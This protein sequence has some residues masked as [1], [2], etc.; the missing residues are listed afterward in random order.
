M[1]NRLP[2]KLTALRKHFGYSQGDMAEK[3]V[4][5]VAEYM[6]WENGNTI[7]RIDQLRQLARIYRVPIEDLADNTRTV[8]L[9]RLDE[10]ADSIQISF[11][12]TKSTDTL[13]GITAS[14]VSAEEAEDFA[15]SLIAKSVAAPQPEP[16]FRND[17]I[18]YQETQVNEIVDEPEEEEYE[19]DEETGNDGNPIHSCSD[20]ESDTGRHPH[21]SS[22]SESSYRTF[23]LYYGTS[24]EETDTRDNL[25]SNTSRISILQ[26]HILLRNIYRHEHG[27]RSSRGDK[28]KCSHTCHLSLLTTLKAYHTSKQ[29]TDKQLVY[30]SNSINFRSAYLSIDF[31]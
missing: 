16:D 2:E 5:P 14:A 11:T 25:C 24:T 8:T 27:K 1:T 7:C 6:N 21:A 29:Q 18:V 17:T 19:E 9:P 20:R 15:D 28:G 3:L 22:S 13:Q 26:P 30:C 23:H 10:D 31:V 12:G 4:V